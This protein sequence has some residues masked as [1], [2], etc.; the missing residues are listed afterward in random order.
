MSSWRGAPPRRPL[1][2]A[3]RIAL[4]PRRL[5]TVPERRSRQPQLLDAART[6]GR[7]ARERQGAPARGIRRSG[8]AAFLPLA[9][10]A[11]MYARL[12]CGAHP[13]RS[14]AVGRK[15][16][17]G[18]RARLPLPGSGPRARRDPGARRPRRPRRRR[19]RRRPV[20]RRRPRRRPRRE[21]PRARHRPR[22]FMEDIARI[23]RF[24]PGPLRRIIRARPRASSRSPGEALDDS[25]LGRRV[26][27]LD[28][29]GGIAP[30]EGHPDEGRRQ[31]RQERRD[32]DG[33]RRLRHQLPDPAE[34]R[35]PA[36]GGAYRAWQHDIAS[37][38]DKRSASARKP[39]SRP[40]ASGARR[41]R[42]A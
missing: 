24:T 5:P 33:G 26:R 23:R 27:G 41:S 12:F 31:A 14:D 28:Q 39:R 21:A 1:Q 16:M 36:S 25:R 2:L 37:R 13:G 32:E 30:R 15:A 10:R 8:V 29:Q 18:R 22:A 7:V 17:L 4:P 20:P 42:W 6:E 40:P 35:G 34:A 38:E 11:P 9:S 19:P 3:A